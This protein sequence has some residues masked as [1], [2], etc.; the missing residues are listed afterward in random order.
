[1]QGQGSYDTCA[2]WVLDIL[3]MVEERIILYTISKFLLFPNFFVQ[4]TFRVV[5]CLYMQEQV[6]HDVAPGWDEALVMASYGK[7]KLSSDTCWFPQF[8]RDGFCMVLVWPAGAGV[9]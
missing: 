3:R 8:F 9:V 4:V 6:P 5:A 1:M 7:R 2:G